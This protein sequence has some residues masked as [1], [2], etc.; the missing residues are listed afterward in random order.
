VCQVPGVKPGQSIGQD[1]LTSPVIVPSREDAI[2]GEGGRK[3]AERAAKWLRAFTGSS[4]G[5]VRVD[6]QRTED[7]ARMEWGLA[8]DG[9]I[10]ALKTIVFFD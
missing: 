6:D 9:L 2:R 1:D 5:V 3:E 8:F 10:L 7:P 4:V